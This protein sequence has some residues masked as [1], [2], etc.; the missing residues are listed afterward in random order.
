VVC[1]QLTYLQ[2]KRPYRDPEPS[3]EDT[4]KIGLNK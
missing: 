4:V 2:G 1:I 3:W